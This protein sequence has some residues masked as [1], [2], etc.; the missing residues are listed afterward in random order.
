MK[1]CVYLENFHY[2]FY[3]YNKNAD[4]KFSAHDAFLE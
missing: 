4:F 1:N 2:T 3:L